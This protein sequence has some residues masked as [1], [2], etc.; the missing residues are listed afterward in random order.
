MDLGKTRE[1]PCALGRRSRG[2]AVCDMEW[3]ATELVAQLPT[4]LP[5]TAQG[6]SS[7]HPLSPS[8][9]KM[10]ILPPFPK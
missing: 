3:G 10:F 4:L 2:R 1:E 8:V 5:P 9:L 6:G 7:I